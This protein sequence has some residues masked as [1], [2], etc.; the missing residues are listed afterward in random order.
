MEIK[1]YINDIP[2]YIAAGIIFVEIQ[3]PI[4]E[5]LNAKELLKDIGL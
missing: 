1:Y 2:S 3:V 5:A 4:S